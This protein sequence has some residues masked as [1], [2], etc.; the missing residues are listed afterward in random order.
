LKYAEKKASEILESW[1][2]EQR[3]YFSELATDLATSVE[4]TCRQFSIS[5][6]VYYQLKK[7]LGLPNKPALGWAK[8]KKLEALRNEQKVLEYL[9]SI[10][11]ICEQKK[12]VKMFPHE[13]VERLIYKRHIFKISF[14]LGRQPGGYKRNLHHFLFKEEYLPNFKGGGMRTFICL[15]RTAVVRLMC[16][17]LKKPV[18]QHVQ[19]TL[20]SFLRRYLSEAEQIAVLWNLGVRSFSAS[21]IKRNMQIDGIL[22]PI[23]RRGE[24][25]P[26]LKRVL[27]A[28]NNMEAS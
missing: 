9:Q 26:T 6:C 12:L 17:A 23:G 13:A 18:N 2:E 15:N 8:H 1:S 20:R 16:K 11:G 14:N 10:G 21:Q 7:K 19:N 27:S 4:E 3:R 25:L 28:L 24:Y 22:G 5:L